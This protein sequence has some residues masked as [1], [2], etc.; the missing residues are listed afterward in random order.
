MAD[1]P[2]KLSP[3]D[4]GF[5]WDECKRCF[6]LKV[7]KGFD[8]PSAPFPKIFNVIDKAMKDSLQHIPAGRWAPGTPGGTYHAADGWVQSKPITLPGRT[9]SCFIRGIFDTVLALDGGGYA[10]VD[11]KTSTIRDNNVKKYARQL[12]AYAFALE[13]SRGTAAELALAPVTALGL[14]VWE[15]RSFA[16]AERGADLAGD[17][18]WLPVERDD[19]GFVRFLDEVLGVLDLPE[20]PPPG[21]DCG[22]CRFRDASRRTGY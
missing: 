1:A 17:L 14:L 4:F 5:L 9:S 12:H 20:P 19:D 13:R 21:R 10:V 11:F 22:F 6:W 8:R 7:A 16:P 15:P 2:C 3:S 18:A